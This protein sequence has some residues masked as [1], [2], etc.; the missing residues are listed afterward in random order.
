ADP[1]DAGTDGVADLCNVDPA[2]ELITLLGGTPDAG[3]SWTDPNGDGHSGTLDPGM[4]MAGVY[5]YTVSASAPCTDASATVT[6]TIGTASVYYA[7]THNDGFG[8]PN[9]ALAACEQ[10]AGYVTN[11]MDNCPSDP[12]KR[13][14]GICGCG[15]ADVDSDLD[16]IAD[17]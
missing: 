3:G 13:D 14:P 8:D 4:D 15:V 1:V 16:G 2:V 9:G 6:I 17:C 5:T 12:L 11:Q 10:P 7:D